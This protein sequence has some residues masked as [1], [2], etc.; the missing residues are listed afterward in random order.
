VIKDRLPFVRTSKGGLRRTADFH[1]FWEAVLAALLIAG[2]ATLV[3]TNTK[4]IREIYIFAAV[5]VVQS[6][7]FL[8]AVALAVI[9]RTPLN[10]FAT[11]RALEGR[12]LELFGRSAPMANVASPA[13][14][15]VP[16]TAAPPSV[17]AQSQSELTP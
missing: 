14:V 13:T 5:L 1:A 4:E 16:V 9:E 15:A 8:A 6:V 3:I 12:L 7:P 10:D 2:A 17:Q 11:W